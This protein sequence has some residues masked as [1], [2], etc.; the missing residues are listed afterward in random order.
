MK[1][2][3]T[4]LILTVA[5]A[6]CACSTKPICNN[7]NESYRPVLDPKNSCHV[8]IRQVLIGSDVE[9]KSLRN[10]TWSYDWQ[11]SRMNDGQL[12][13]GH[14]VLTPISPRDGKFE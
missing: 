1:R 14:F 2:I 12:V 4:L 9:P 7:G 13:L 8:R 5:C 6:L 10:T 3:S 11:P